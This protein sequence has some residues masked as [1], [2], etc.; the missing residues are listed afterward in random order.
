MTMLVVQEPRRDGASEM[1]DGCSTS[2]A[3]V[4]PMDRERRRD[5]RVVHKRSPA[6]AAALSDVAH[7]G[8]QPLDVPFVHEGV[9]TCGEEGIAELGAVA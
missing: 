4:E 2:G 9:G 5:R 1:W 3:R 6:T 8:D 7:S